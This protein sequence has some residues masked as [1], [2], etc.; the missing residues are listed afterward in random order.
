M[1]CEIKF[2]SV[3]CNAN[4][5]TFF[6]I[7]YFFSGQDCTVCVAVYSSITKLPACHV[8]RVTHKDSTVEGVELIPVGHLLEPTGNA[9]IST[10]FCV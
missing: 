5:T 2:Y 7:I 10:S 1:K 8:Y 4:F 9:F 3:N 6:M